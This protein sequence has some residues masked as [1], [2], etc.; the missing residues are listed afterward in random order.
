MLLCDNLLTQL[1]THLCLAR[2]ISELTTQ[3]NPLQFPPPQVMSQGWQTVREYLA[4]FC[5]QGERLA[6]TVQGAKTLHRLHILGDLIKTTETPSSGYID[7]GEMTNTSFK[8][9]V[10]FENN[11][12]ICLASSSD[13]IDQIRIFSLLTFIVGLFI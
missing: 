10:R 7:E 1:P 8:K 9:T 2:N 11:G 12:S 13:E 3:G 4:R 6:L 5:K